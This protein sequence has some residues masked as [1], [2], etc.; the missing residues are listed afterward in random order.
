MRAA[1]E[2]SRRPTTQRK[3]WVTTPRKRSRASC[4]GGR[5]Q[6]TRRRTALRARV[7]GDACGWRDARPT[8]H[9]TVHC[10]SPQAAADRR[11]TDVQNQCRQKANEAPR[12]HK[13]AG[14][15]SEAGGSSFRRRSCQA[16]R[17][18]N[19]RSSALTP[20]F[21]TRHFPVNLRFGGPAS[22]GFAAGLPAPAALFGAMGA[23]ALAR[24]KKRLRTARC[25]NE[26]SSGRS[27]P[28]PG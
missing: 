6:A 12:P 25:A 24:P 28:R 9:R 10:A 22:L 15:C 16:L 27:A 5:A 20:S 13:G 8:Q 26:A 2:S 23:G 11:S 19:L 21:P 18:V 17:S 14:V 7:R 1:R 4:R 3:P